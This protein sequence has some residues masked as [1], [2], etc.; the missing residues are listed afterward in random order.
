MK[1]ERNTISEF[2][3]THSHLDPF[4]LQLYNLLFLLF[5]GHG[6]PMDVI[7]YT[8]QMLFRTGEFTTNTHYYDFIDATF[9]EYEPVDWFGY[10][11]RQ[12]YGNLD[13]VKGALQVCNFD[14]YIEKSSQGSS[15]I[16]NDKTLYNGLEVFY[17]ITSDDFT[18]T[19]VV[20]YIQKQRSFYPVRYPKLMK[21]FLT[22]NQE[23]SLI[24]DYKSLV[25]RDRIQYRRAYDSA[26]GYKKVHRF[27]VD[28]RITVL[29]RNDKSM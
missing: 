17:R 18:I 15:L 12:R 20:R 29:L 6:I 23:Y 3:D 9:N 7:L 8:G 4:I 1:R 26:V 24:T 28:G 13:K 14:T 25:H 11:L 22:R 10:R 2:L 16:P 19:I 21:I 27:A 5:Q